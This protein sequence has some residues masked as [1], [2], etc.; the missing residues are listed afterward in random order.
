MDMASHVEG[1]G[2]RV[3]VEPKLP[4]IE[5]STK[6]CCVRKGGQG[7][8]SAPKRLQLHRISEISYGKER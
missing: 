3:E 5:S 2:G 8:K 7:S 1:D 4:L 6:G